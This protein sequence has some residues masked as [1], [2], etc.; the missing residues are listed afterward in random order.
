MNLEILS[1]IEQNI[2]IFHHSCHV[3][4]IVVYVTLSASFRNPISILV[5]IVSQLCVTMWISKKYCRKR[6]LM[7]VYLF[8]HFG[9]MQEIQNSHS[10]QISSQADNFYYSFTEIVR[11]VIMTAR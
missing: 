4:F 5:V 3:R 11:T 10:L 9:F 8:N 1:R 6:N 2:N 7:S